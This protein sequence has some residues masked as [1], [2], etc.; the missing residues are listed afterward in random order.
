[1]QATR[2]KNDRSKYTTKWDLNEIESCL[3]TI[4]FALDVILSRFENFAHNE[5]S[6]MIKQLHLLLIEIILITII[7]KNYSKML[8]QWLFFS[9]YA[10]LQS[11]IHH[12]KSYLLVEHARWSIIISSLLRLWLRKKHIQSLY[13]HKLKQLLQCSNN[14]IVEIIIKCFATLAKSN[15][16]LMIDVLDEEDRRNVVYFVQNFRQ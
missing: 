16:V 14:Q 6:E 4:S 9:N 3:I 10:R 15:N 2:L 8:R 13:M 1:M 5:Y 7:D 12:L 11:L